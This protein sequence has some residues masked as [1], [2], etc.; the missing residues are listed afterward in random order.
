MANKD[1]RLFA[2]REMRSE[3]ASF[4]IERRKRGPRISHR[5]FELCLLRW[6]R[7]PE[8]LG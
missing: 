3:Q 7:H 1:A 8:V 4:K 5:L 6:V 2:D